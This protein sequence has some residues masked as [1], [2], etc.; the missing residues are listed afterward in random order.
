MIGDHHVDPRQLGDLAR[1]EDRLGGVGPGRPVVVEDPA[2]AVGVAERAE[3]APLEGLDPVVAVLV[4]SLALWM[5][6]FSSTSTP[7]PREAGSAAT[8]TAFSRFRSPSALS[9]RRAA[10]RRPAPPVG[11]LGDL[12]ELEHAGDQLAV[13]E[14]LAGLQVPAKVE[15]VG[16]DRVDGPSGDHQRHAPASLRH[17]RVRDQAGALSAQ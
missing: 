16:A 9:P 15:T 3:V 5:V 17:A 6:S 4:T 11:G 7:A 8:R 10:W 2:V 13:A 14:P 12:V 1:L